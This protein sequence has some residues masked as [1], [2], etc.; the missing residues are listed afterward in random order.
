MPEFEW[1]LFSFSGAKKKK[2][3]INRDDTE[4]KE[5]KEILRRELTTQSKRLGRVLKKL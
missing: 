4:K 1:L 3:E 5:T 2:N